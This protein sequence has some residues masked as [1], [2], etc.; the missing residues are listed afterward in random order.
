MEPTVKVALI[1]AVPPTFVGL[2]SLVLGIIN[3]GKISDVHL[4]LNSR[5]DQLIKA[6]LAQGR[7][8]ERDSHSITVTGVPAKEQP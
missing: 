8:D 5:L 2:A 3:K 1:A 4:S 7:Q 6:S